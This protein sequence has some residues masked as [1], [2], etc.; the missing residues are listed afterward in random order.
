MVYRRGFRLTS[1][2]F[3]QALNIS[4]EI[5]DVEMNHKTD[6]ITIVFYGNGTFQVAE[7]QETPLRS[8]EDWNDHDKQFEEEL[9]DQW[10]SD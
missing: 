3:A 4:G 6:T 7:G 10:E 5:R 9:I 8:I 2:A 1:Q